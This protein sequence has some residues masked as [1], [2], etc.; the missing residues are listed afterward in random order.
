MFT[1]KIKNMQ[2]IFSACIVV[3]SFVFLTPNAHAQPAQPIPYDTLY[4]DSVEDQISGWEIVGNNPVA[5]D[6]VFLTG[7]TADFKIISKFKFPLILQPGQ[8]YNITVQFKPL[9]VGEKTATLVQHTDAGNFSGGVITQQLTADKEIIKLTAQQLNFG[10]LKSKQ[11]PVREP[12]LVTNSG[13]VDEIITGVSF[14]PLLPFTLISSLPDTIPVGTTDSLMI[15]F[16][17][18]PVD[19]TY[20][21]VLTIDDAPA[22]NTPLITTVNGSLY[23]ATI[24]SAQQISL[25]ELSCGIM[26]YDTFYV[27]N[28]G[29]D[30]LFISSAVFHVGKRGYSLAFPSLPDTIMPFDS[31]KF[32]VLFQP[33]MNGNYTD[34]LDVFSNDKSA[35]HNPWQI[36]FSGRKDSIAFSVNIPSF[37]DLGTVCFDQ[38]IIIDSSIQNTGTTNVT[39][40][41]T[42]QPPAVLSQMQWTLDTVNR[43][44]RMNVIFTA[45][46]HGDIHDTLIFTD[47]LCHTKQTVVIHAYVPT[48]GILASATDFGGVCLGDTSKQNMMLYNIGNDTL[49]ITSITLASGFTLLTSLPITIFPGDSSPITITFAPTSPSSYIANAVVQTLSCGD[50]ALTIAR[51]E[52]IETVLRLTGGFDFGSVCIGDTTTETLMLHNDG[53]DTA[54]II[55]IG[56]DSLQ[57][58][59]VK[60][61]FHVLKQSP[62]LIAPRD[63]VPIVISFAPDSMNAYTDSLRITGLPCGAI[64]DTTILG[65]GISVSLHAANMTFPVIYTDGQ[66]DT[67]IV[68]YNSGN[69]LAVANIRIESL[70]PSHASFTIDG[71]NGATPDTNITIPAQDSARIQVHYV[72]A[73]PAI[74]LAKIFFT[75]ILSCND[76]SFAQITATSIAPDTANICIA[77]PQS[78]SPG[79]VATADIFMTDSI[80]FH[81]DSLK[82]VFTYVPSAMALDTIT[83]MNSQGCNLFYQNDPP[84]LVHIVLTSCGNPLPPGILCTAQFL[85]LITSTDTTYARLGIDTVQAYPLSD[86]IRRQGCSIDV[87][88]LPECGISGVVY[89]GAASISQNYPNP[90]V[91]TTTIH[92]TLPTSD[93]FDAH[94]HTY[95]CVYNILGEQVADLTNQIRQ[96]TDVTFNSGELTAGVYYYILE[97]EKGRYLREMFITR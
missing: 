68:I 77:A 7:D 59:S 2:V 86:S 72:P 17:L 67:T 41:A 94:L 34:T 88:V 3:T 71:A 95:L 57:G 46:S 5:I 74:D 80:T 8:N 6:T 91:Q 69:S 76:S 54:D 55:S 27:H 26:E 21:A 1:C 58:A 84:G 83:I 43:S 15:Q 37:D 50:S 53:V 61:A 90:F 64:I 35:G 12:M 38:Q 18:P 11:F 9:S 42:S 49:S 79:H 36:S 20:S 31:T 28:I 47:T 92:V 96:T 30:S 29:S 14:V 63:S 4:C 23:S 56:F 51:G 19:R 87:T 97:T 39:I 81:T 13:T 52:G 32:I 10:R 33:P 60:N 70:P 62:T 40:T 24:A 78:F 25:L 22:C 16:S 89:L 45:N 66:I 85:P 82:L 73:G 75:S 65:S 48:P 44:Q 93:T